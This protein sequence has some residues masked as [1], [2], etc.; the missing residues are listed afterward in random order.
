M[1]EDKRRTMAAAMIARL[2]VLERR[3]LRR[4]KEGGALWRT[5]LV[6]PTAREAV[7]RGLAVGMFWGCMPM[8]FQMVPALLCCLLLRANM[9]LA[10]V[11]VWLSNPF[12][13]LPIFYVEYLIGESLFGAQDGVFAFARFE[14]LFEDG[15]LFALFGKLSGELLKPL[16]QGALVLGVAA[17]AAGYG[18]GFPAHGF[19]Q[20]HYHR[21]KRK[22]QQ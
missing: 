21:A 2:R 17:A 4:A 11:C 15:D 1:T 8:P 18:L 12:T 14:R 13:Y 10:L 6:F 9:V 7:C 16:L 19:L 5:D 22:Q 3:V 20:R